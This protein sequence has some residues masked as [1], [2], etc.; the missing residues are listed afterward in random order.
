M[1]RTTAG[2]RRRGRAPVGLPVAGRPGEV[3]VHHQG[4]SARQL[5]LRHVR[6]AARAGG[7]R[8]CQ[9]GHHR[10]ADG[11][12]LHAQGHRHLGRPGGALDPRRRRPGRRH[13]ARGLR[14]RPVHRRAGRALRRRAAGLHGGADVR[15]PDRE[16][17]AADHRLPARHHHGHAQLHA[18]DRRGDAAPGP[19]PARQ[20]AE[21]GH[22]RRRALDRGDAPRHRGAR[23][24]G[25]GGHLRPE[26]GDGPGRGQR[27]RRDQGRPGDLGGPLLPG[28]HRPRNRRGA[29]RRRGGR[30]GLHHADQGGAAGDP[31]PHARPDA[32]AAA[33]RAKHAPHGQDRRPQRRHADHPRRQ[34]L[35]HAGGRAGAQAR[36]AV[37][38]VPAGGHAPGHAGRGAGAVRAG[39]GP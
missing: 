27:M 14:L 2:L 39:A 10:Q 9:L 25:R 18:G 33:H 3:P 17:G 16:A 4:R 28:D 23:R 12:G 35:P 38:A 32:A 24:P 11:G 8:A 36:P 20:L 30:A 37:G 13:G 5:P 7:A 34:R 15:R 19:G 29:A 22:L 31:L 21:G 26:R 1:C 6:R